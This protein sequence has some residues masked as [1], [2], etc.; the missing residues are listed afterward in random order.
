MNTVSRDFTSGTAQAGGLTVADVVFDFLAACGIDR[1]FGNP[2]STELPMFVNLPDNFS[3]V[4]G[5][6]ESIVVAMA[7]AYA[8]VSGNAAFVNLHSAAG[9][10][11]ALGNIYTAYRN[12]APLI[13]TTGQ[14][15]RSLL[16]HDPFLFAES[17][18]DFPKP[19]VKWACEPARPEDV[20]A[21]IARA[22]H[23]A[24][25]A[26]RG[27]VMVSIPLSD[28]DMPATALLD[29]R[30]VET[31]FTPPADALDRLA[32]RLDRARETVLVVGPGVDIDGAW[33][34]TVALA[35]RIKAK[36]WVSP[37]SS[38]GSFPERHPLFAGFLP[39]RQPHLLTCLGAA[40]LVLVLGSPAFT[41]HFAGHG[42]HVPAGAELCLISDD[43]AHIA[44]AVMGSALRSNIR[45]AV[46]GLTQRV[47][48]RAEPAFPLPA[49][50]VARVSEP[51]GI[52]AAFFY[53]TLADLR[54]P[55]SI[56]VE[57][58]PSAR[59]D[60][61]DHFPIE[62]PG[63]FFATASGGL[64]YGLAA[65]VGAALTRPQQPVI[66]VIGDGSSLYAIQSLWSAVEYA[67]DLFVVILNN[68]GYAALKGIGGAGNNRI[69]GV[70]IG[71]IDFV[72]I[73]EAQ[74]CPGRR[75]ARG[76]ELPDCLRDLLA[77]KG[78]RLLE[79]MLSE[80]E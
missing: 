20:P 59:G 12:R 42:G 51:R 55:D 60:L 25:Q 62:R 37:L 48:H 52:T 30:E 45:L 67:A 22:Y 57:E 2:G 36:V 33:D 54:S 53:Q 5:L 27:P 3:Y 69:D 47:A 35:E 43:P 24:M 76:S 15:V 63:G 58:A 13:I 11:H 26:P 28:W 70:E 18:T 23:M 65:S 8:Q 73:A 66:A 71:H 74:G 31:A 9:L 16:P 41:Y 72:A 7:D 75:C 46:E 14:Q 64:G 19:Y 68:G 38:R 78:P 79:I 6:Q 80:E 61:H 49:R 39:A 56:V 32:A 17:P 34:A 1:I 44:G 29:K 21:A 40:D 10:G 4:L 77:M 50:N